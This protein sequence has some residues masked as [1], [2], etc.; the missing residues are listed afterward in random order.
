MVSLRRV[1]FDELSIVVLET[2]EGLYFLDISRWLPFS[3]CS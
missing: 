1:A 2:Q 3:D